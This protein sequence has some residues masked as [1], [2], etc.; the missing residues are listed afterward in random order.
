MIFFFP[1]NFFYYFVYYTDT[2]SS[3]SIVMLI[4]SAQFSL[5]QRTSSSVT[6]IQQIA[7]SI[8]VRTHATLFILSSFAILCRQT[9]AIWVMFCIGIVMLSTLVSCGLYNPS[10]TLTAATTLSFL[11][12]LLLNLPSLLQLCFSLL[13][14]VLLFLLF[15]FG[16]NGGSIVVGQ[17]SLS[18]SFSNSQQAIRTITRC[19]YILLYHC[20]CFCSLL[21]Y[22]VPQY[23]S[24][25]SHRRSFLPIRRRR[26]H[27]KESFGQFSHGSLGRSS[28][29]L[30]SISSPSLIPFSSLII[31]TLP[32]LSLPSSLTSSLLPGS[33]SCRHLTFYLWRYILSK[34]VYR[35]AFL[36][37]L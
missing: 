1:L 34:P 10:P 13:L 29:Q 4:Y 3:L 19:L 24:C 22:L 36:L 17:L 27:D 20:I 9:N 30:S 11:Q 21:S 14:P 26:W 5:L 23:S 37:V 28:Q 12:S 33:S 7:T 15:I 16:F 2:I 6:T 8:P 25:G 18:P 31:G 35:S 32:R